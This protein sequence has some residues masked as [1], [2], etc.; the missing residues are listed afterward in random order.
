MKKMWCIAKID[1]EYQR[2][3]FRILKLYSEDYN[4]K[5]PIICFDE[6]QKYLISDLKENIP[7]KPGI[8]GKYDYTY[9]IT[10]STNIF[11]AV[12]FNGGKRDIMVTDRRTKKDFAM[13]ITFGG[14]CVSKC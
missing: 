13:Y 10:G 6:K 5:Y 2:R 8:S 3:M 9:K 14:Q 4:P 7:M 1:S 12:D 11:V